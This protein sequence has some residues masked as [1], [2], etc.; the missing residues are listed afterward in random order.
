M[1]RRSL[2]IISILLIHSIVY[3]GGDTFWAN[4]GMGIGT[5]DDGTTFL[6]N[7][8]YQTRNHV[9]TLRALSTGTAILDKGKTMNDVGLLYNRVFKSS[10]IH[11]S[12]GAGLA[13][14]CGTID[15]TGFTLGGTDSDKDEKLGPT[16]GLPLDVQLFLRPL[17]FLGLGLYGFADINPEESFLGFA[18]CLQLGKLK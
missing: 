13:V 9:Y 8:S 12:A 16:I 2:V 6:G 15:S 4:L 5:V 18:L 3:A 7:L 14:V 1:K 11:C 10:W 17:P